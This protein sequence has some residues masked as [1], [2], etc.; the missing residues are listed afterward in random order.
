[1]RNH[2]EPE[3][4]RQ[5]LQ[6]G[7]QVPKSDWEYSTHVGYGCHCILMFLSEISTLT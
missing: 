3:S 7:P 5:T 2:E 4:R 6:V 1:M